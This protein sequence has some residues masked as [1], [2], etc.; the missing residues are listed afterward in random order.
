MAQTLHSNNKTNK[1][2]RIVDYQKQVEKD[3]TDLGSEYAN[4]SHMILGLTSTIAKLLESTDEKQTEH[5][6]DLMYYTVNLARIRGILADFDVTQ[7]PVVLTAGEYVIEIVSLVGQL[8]DMYKKGYVNGQEIGQIEEYFMIHDLVKTIADTYVS[9]GADFR[10]GLEANINKQKPAEKELEELP[11]LPFEVEVNDEEA[12]K[13][14]RE[15]L[16]DIYEATSVG[17]YVDK[18]YTPTNTTQED[19]PTW[20]SSST[21]EEKIRFF[22]DGLKELLVYKNIKYNNSIQNSTGILSHLDPEDKIL[23][24]IDDKLN[25]IIK[26]NVPKENDF[27]DLVGYLVQYCILKEFINFEKYY[28]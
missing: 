18:D 28:E 16:E 1:N 27:L 21:T 24:R 13:I 7:E 14:L 17:A 10:S 3:C 8:S 26:S 5:M 12:V 4:V 23:S 11:E 22:C 25:R 15:I 2:M 19:V 9:L 6:G 20:T